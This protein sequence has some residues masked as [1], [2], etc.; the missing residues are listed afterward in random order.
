[1]SKKVKVFVGTSKGGFIFESDENRK[2]WQTSDIQFKSWNMMH[3]QLD[4]RDMR[5]HAAVSHNVYGPTTHYSDDFGKTWVQAKQVPVLTRASNSGRPAG[6]VNEAF[7]QVSTLNVL[8][9]SQQPK[10]SR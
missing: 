4:P 3:M 7:N 6:T 1:M 9:S 2:D 5:L 8:A 10:Q